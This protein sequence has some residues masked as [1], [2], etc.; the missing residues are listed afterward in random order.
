MGGAVKK[1]FSKPKLPPRDTRLDAELAA[2]RKREEDRKKQ[3]EAAQAE[4]S[5]ALGMGW[6]GSRSLFGRA[7][8]RGYFDQT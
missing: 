2:A 5:F 8:G 6:V 3:A 4:K 7:G 1:I